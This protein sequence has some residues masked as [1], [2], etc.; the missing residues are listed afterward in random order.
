LNSGNPGVTG[1]HCLSCSRKQDLSRK[2]FGV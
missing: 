2:G 1:T